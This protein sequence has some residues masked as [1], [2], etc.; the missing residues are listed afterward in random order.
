MTD[1]LDEVLG[2]PAVGGRHRELDRIRVLA[3]RR[4]VLLPRLAREGRVDRGLDRAGAGVA[5]RRQLEL[6]RHVGLRRAS[7]EDAA[8]EPVHGVLAGGAGLHEGVDE[9]VALALGDDLRLTRADE[10]RPGTEVG[11]VE[12]A[13]FEAG[14]VGSRQR[15]DAQVE[16]RALGRARGHHAL[17][18]D[19]G[20]VGAVEEALGSPAFGARRR[21]ADAAPRELLDH[22]GADF[23]GHQPP[24]RL[25][26]PDNEAVAAHDDGIQSGD[27]RLARHR[28]AHDR[29]D[30]EHEV[31]GIGAVLPRPLG[32]LLDDLAAAD[33]GDREEE[34]RG[35]AREGGANG[36]VHGHDFRVRVSAAGLEP[37][38]PAV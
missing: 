6:E 36:S 10:K 15:A 33:D 7:V 34:R 3:A 21:I 5:R 29:V 13:A 30:I 27:G 9:D 11:R 26:E 16:L 37:A 14:D 19:D 1:K 12:T 17:D 38:T 25:L 24:A 8:D 35:E 32:D 2:L 4:L 20:G 31:G 18:D 22:H 28:P 23:G